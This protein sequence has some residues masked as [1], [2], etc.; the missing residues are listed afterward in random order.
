MRWL[1]FAALALYVRFSL[2][3]ITCYEGNSVSGVKLCQGEQ[4]FTGTVEGLAWMGKCIPAL[5]DDCDGWIKR[6]TGMI[7]DNW[8]RRGKND[9]DVGEKFREIKGECCHSNECNKPDE[10]KWNNATVSEDE[11]N[12]TWCRTGVFGVGEEIR[13]KCDIGGC[14]LGKRWD[15]VKIGLCATD[16]CA[17]TTVYAGELF[18]NAS[19]KLG[20][21]D[22]ARL[23]RHI[24]GGCCKTDFC[25]AE[26]IPTPHGG[27]GSNVTLTCYKGNKTNGT[28]P[29]T[30]ERGQH[31]FTAVDENSG[32]WI[33][34]CA[35]G[36]CATYT[37]VMNSQ[38]R[39]VLFAS[40]EVTKALMFKP[41]KGQCC[42]TDRCNKPLGCSAGMS[43]DASTKTT[44]CAPG[45]QC[46]T[47]TYLGQWV[48]GCATG[49]CQEYTKMLAEQ[50]GFTGFRALLWRGQCCGT[51]GCN[52]GNSR[53]VII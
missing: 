47:G 19:E 41:L 48:K 2:A 45:Q 25:N 46:W 28:K 14:W 35:D 36:D 20:K 44:N 13:R 42:H 7:S 40:G 31:C 17:Q 10:V 4:C 39:A 22:E 16:D 9:T 27:S 15:G 29:V 5:I 1:I 50:G 3:D 32:E 23:V 24:R 51:D 11:K 52:S 34:D 12:G 53:S 49:D 6:T 18:A 30:C 33:S 21:L 37:R 8:A 38:V 43:M 26:D